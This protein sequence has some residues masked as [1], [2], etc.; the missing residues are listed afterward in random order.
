M[1]DSDRVGES[2]LPGAFRGVIERVAG[3]MGILN[4]DAA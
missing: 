4:D 2:A 3:V 1:L